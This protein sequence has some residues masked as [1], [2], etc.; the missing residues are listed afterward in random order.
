MIEM[1]GVLAIVGVLSA[2]GIAG[3]SMAME[4]YRSTALLEKVVSI[5]QQARVLYDGYYSETATDTTNGG[6]GKRLIEAGF[7]SDLNNPFG[8]ALKTEPANDDDKAMFTIT[9]DANIPVNA[10]IRLVTSNWGG[11]G[12][13]LEISANDDDVVLDS[14]PAEAD[15]AIEACVIK[16]TNTGVKLQWLAH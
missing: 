6:M 5:A 14:F 2:G 10:C 16:D 11:E 9:S 13:I 12:T 4:S 15:D 7:L 1:L 8:G 3:Y